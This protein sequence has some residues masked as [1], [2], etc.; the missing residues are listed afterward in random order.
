LH[1]FRTDSKIATA[2]SKIFWRNQGTAP[3]GFAF[4]R[5]S[6]KIVGKRRMLTFGTYGEAEKVAMEKSVNF[7][8]ASN[9]L[10]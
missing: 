9:R 2:R 10:D 5:I 4:C 1:K 3:E 7:T 6:F 8:R